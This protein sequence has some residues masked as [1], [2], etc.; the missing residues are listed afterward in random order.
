MTRVS[1][2]WLDGWRRV[3]AAPWIAGG[4]VALTIGAALPLTVV[5]Y[6]L[7]SAHLDGS[8]MADEVARGISYDWWQEFL[9]QASGLGS[10]FSPRILGFAATLDALSS[11]ADTRAEVTPIVAALI[12][13]VLLWTYISAGVIDRYARGR[14]IGA[15]GFAAACGRH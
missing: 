14:A 6:T 3:M 13:Y 7:L 8:L 5:M 10:T 2:A 1:A 4:V 12:V 9:S 15:Q 11:V